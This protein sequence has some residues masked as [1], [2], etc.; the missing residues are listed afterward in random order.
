[1]TALLVVRFVWP[2]MFE[3]VKAQSIV[4]LPMVKF[5]IWKE[6]RRPTWLLSGRPL[7]RAAPRRA[8]VLQA[9]CM[10]HR[11]LGYFPDTQPATRRPM[12]S[13]HP[14]GILSNELSNW[15]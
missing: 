10:T 8:G 5:V 7:M 13:V 14:R 9:T 6:M 2:A 1:M 12:I 11:M 15:P 3:F 4:M